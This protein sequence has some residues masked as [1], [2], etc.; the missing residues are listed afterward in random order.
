MDC[1]AAKEFLSQN[2]FSYRDYDVVKNPEKEQEMVKR[3]GNRIVPGIVIRKRT[4]LGIRSKEY[5]FTG[6]ENNRND[7]VSLLDK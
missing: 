2:D 5:K 1:K 7:I 6:F 3:L 4:L